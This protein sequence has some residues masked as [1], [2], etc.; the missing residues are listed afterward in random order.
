M[1]RHEVLDQAGPVEV[2]ASS[3]ADDQPFTKPG[4]WPAIAGEV[5]AAEEGADRRV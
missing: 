5:E 4:E 1:R 2:I 3:G